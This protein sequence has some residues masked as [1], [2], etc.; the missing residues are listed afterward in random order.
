[1]NDQKIQSK[2]TIFN[3][4][5]I[6]NVKDFLL[7]QPITN[8]NQPLSIPTIVPQLTPK[9]IDER[10]FSR[11]DGFLYATSLSGFRESPAGL[12]DA[13]VAWMDTKSMILDQR[14]LSATFKPNV[15]QELQRQLASQGVRLPNG[16]ENVPRNRLLA[17]VSNNQ[18][19]NMNFVDL[20]EM[21][22]THWDLAF[23]EV[24]KPKTP[25]PTD[26]RHTF[27]RLAL[28]ESVL[29]LLAIYETMGGLQ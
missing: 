1:M 7:P 18:M 22:G 4:S 11:D 15:I 2:T 25:S 27:P 13:Q 26:Y 6:A 12:F 9:G 8:P 5:A 16:F 21:R 14:P 23:E 20:G 29:E 24:Y 10:K 17:A 3:L 28:Q 19:K